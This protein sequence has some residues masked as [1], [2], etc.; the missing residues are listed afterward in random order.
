MT[1]KKLGNEFEREFC[2]YL[3]QHGF[4]VLNVTQNAA[5]Q[6]ADVVAVKNKHAYLIDCKVCSRRGFV[7]SRIEPNQEMSMSLW[8]ECGNGTG[9]FAIK[10][11]NGEIWM[12]PSIVLNAIKADTSV[13]N[14][15]TL[16]KYGMTVKEWVTS[17]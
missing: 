16:I 17:K 14:R 9:W 10:T 12:V 2:E 1:N 8:N 6:P 11:M 13:L 15:K 5:G 3:F 4:W 7:L